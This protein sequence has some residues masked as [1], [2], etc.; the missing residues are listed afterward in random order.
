MSESDLSGKVVLVTGASRGIGAG[1]ASALLDGGAS[2][3]VHYN[4]GAAEARALVG[5]VAAERVCLTRA[6]LL[7]PDAP[8]R[9][10]RDA[11]AFKGRVDVLVNNAAVR[12]SCGLDEDFESVDRAWCDSM[13]VNATAPAHLCRL[14][15]AHWRERDAGEARKRGGIIINVSSRPAFRGDR[16]HFYHDGA[17]KAA[18]TSLT[19]GLA[20]FCAADNVTAFAVVPGI[21]ETGQTIGYRKHYDISEALAEIPMGEFG[22][23]ADVGKIVAFLA[24]G[25]ARYA[26]GATIDVSG[27]SYIH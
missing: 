20:R 15:V 24:S 10:W 25:D 1:I 6:D 18:L 9:I 7:E 23:P 11:L 26:T 21:I 2:V 16:P 5:G 22:T 27:A 17:S 12:L 3:V 4:R 19:Y 14:A 13:R 8:L